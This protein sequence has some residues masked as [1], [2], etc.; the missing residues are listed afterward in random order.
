MI[1]ALP[2]LSVSVIA[3][4]LAAVENRRDAWRE[5]AMELD[6][7]YRSVFPMIGRLVGELDGFEVEIFKSRSGK[8]SSIVIEVRPV[9]PGFSLRRHPAIATQAVRNVLVGET[10]LDQR[11]LIEG[12][13]ALALAALDPEIR[14]TLDIVVVHGDGVVDDG[15]IRS[16]VRSIDHA[17]ST[18]DAMLVLAR[19][20]RRPSPDKVP[21]LLAQRARHDPLAT[22]RLRAFRELASC[23]G[24]APLLATARSLRESSELPLG[25]QALSVLLHEP[26]PEGTAAAEDLI[27]L[28]KEKEFGVTLSRQA[29]VALADSEFGELA[30]ST[31]VAILADPGSYPSVRAAAL[32]S[33]IRGRHLDE[34]LALKPSSDAAEAARLARGLGSLRDVAAQ[35]RLVE[36]LEHAEDGV[37]KAAA[38]ALGEV[39]NLEAV[40]PLR[41]IVRSAGVLSLAVA[42]A[43]ESAI[44]EIQGRAGNSQEGEISLVGVSQLDGAV[45]AVDGAAVTKGGEVSHAS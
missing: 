41:A 17:P 36:M 3:L 30:T 11:V 45:S 32:Q 34:L 12:D 18:L 39:G 5:H 9:D 16:T 20:L 15:M 21:F 29:L 35:P 4:I 22:V 7:H 8:R 2:W 40:R 28:V 37:R 25:L 44:A 23:H 19:E 10:E 43:A 27:R 24:S 26:A 33:L 13:A 6:L 38:E 31:L 1:E 42:Q 14:R